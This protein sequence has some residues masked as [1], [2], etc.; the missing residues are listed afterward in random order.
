M[1]RRGHCVKTWSS[2]QATVALSIAEA[3]LY[4][5]TKG[6]AQGLGMMTL[7]AYF[8]T[9][10]AV[11]VTWLLSLPS[12]GSLSLPSAGPPPCSSFERSA[13]ETLLMEL[14][15]CLCGPGLAGAGRA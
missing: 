15:A 13:F 11:M 6:A 8:G 14:A 9:S 2:T 10:V 12:A 4:A 5:L 1:L 3:E 7:L